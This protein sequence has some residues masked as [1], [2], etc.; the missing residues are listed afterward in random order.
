MKKNILLITGQFIPYT[1]SIGGVIRIYSF[2][3]SLKKK[4]N[5]Y[6]LANSGNYNGYLGLS[7][8]NL[9]FINITYLKKKNKLVKLDLFKDF[10]FFKIIKNFFYLV[11]I[12][13]TFASTSRYFQETSKIIESKK[14]DYIII[15]GP[16]FSLFFLIKKIKKNFPYIKIIVDYRDGWTGRINNLSL[17]LIK[18][19]VRN[20]IEKKI[21]HYVEYI[22]VATNNIKKNLSYIT[23]KKIILITNGYINNF[24]NTKLTKHNSSTSEKILVGYFGLISDQSGGYRDIKILY[25]IFKNDLFLQ[26]KYIFYFFGNNTIFN[27]SIKN[28]SI[29]KFKKNVPYKKVLSVMS[30]M[31]YLLCLHTD[32]NTSKEVIT[33]KLYEYISSRRP[34][35][36]ISAGGTE[37]GEIVKKYRLGYSINYLKTN[38]NFFF[39]NLKK[40]SKLRDNKNISIFSR[41]VQNKKLLK[42]I[43]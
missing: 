43:K 21:L 32:Q 8:N 2:L 27:T 41:K 10:V 30:Q 42:I 23:K 12:D 29:F 6:L 34:I 14:I 36:F 40:N 37:G 38:L 25:N 19:I 20:F 26:N 1:K 15:S 28:F 24:N 9:D 7:K 11:S 3:Q 13:R 5:I 16:P 22:L 35:I 31:D 18:K 17:L 4:H 33:G 39:N